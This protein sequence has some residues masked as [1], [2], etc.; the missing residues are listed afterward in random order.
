[1]P[2]AQPDSPLDTP[3]VDDDWRGG[4]TPGRAMLDAPVGKGWLVDRLGL[5][6][7]LLAFDAVVSAPDGTT[8]VDV[9]DNEP[10]PGALRR[11]AGDGLFG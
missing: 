1:V 10:G 5:D 11:A 2:T 3:D 8:Q 4:P 9:G 6:F 7:T